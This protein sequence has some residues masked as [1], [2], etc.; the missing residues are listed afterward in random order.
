MCIPA[1]IATMQITKEQQKSVVGLQSFLSVPQATYK[2]WAVWV[3]EQNGQTSYGTKPANEQILLRHYVKE[4]AIEQINT[5]NC[6]VISIIQCI[7]LFNEEE[8]FHLLG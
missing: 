7:E 5:H 3:Q 2:S 8:S 1:L 4:C 6:G